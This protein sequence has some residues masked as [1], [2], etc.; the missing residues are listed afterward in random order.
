[1]GIRFQYVDG[2]ISGKFIRINAKFWRIGR[3]VRIQNRLLL[4][5][6]N[7]NVFFKLGLMLIYEEIELE[8]KY[9]ANRFGFSAARALKSSEKGYFQLFC[10][11]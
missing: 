7:F 9:E 10:P 8:M 4:W 3:S 1:M 6:S 2:H 5:A 11:T